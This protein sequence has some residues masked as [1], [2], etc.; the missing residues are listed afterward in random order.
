MSGDDIDYDELSSNLGNY[1]VIDVRNKEELEKMGKIPGSV[2][3]PI[4]ELDE[5]MDM[6]DDDFQEKYGSPK[7]TS[8]QTLVTQCQMGGRARRAADALAGKGYQTRTYPGSFKDWTTKGGQV[9]AVN[10]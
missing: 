8:D 1:V 10:P 5:A 6:N 3:I 7:P 9:D 2:N 4:S